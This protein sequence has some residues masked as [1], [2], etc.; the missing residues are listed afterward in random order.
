MKKYHVLWKNYFHKLITGEDISNLRQFVESVSEITVEDL[1]EASNIDLIKEKAPKILEKQM[2]AVQKIL[3][4]ESASEGWK[5]KK[6]NYADIQL[7]ST[8][9]PGTSLLLFKIIGDIK[10]SFDQV[11]YFCSDPT[12]W[13][14]INPS[15]KN[16]RTLER[17]TDNLAIEY[18]YTT[19]PFISDRD[20]VA[21]RY[22]E[23]LE[24]DGFAINCQISVEHDDCPPIKGCVRIDLFGGNIFRQIGKNH[25]KFT[26]ITYVDAKGML[27]HAPD[28]II[29][30]AVQQQADNLFKLKKF[31]ESNSV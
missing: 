12:N 29:K 9:M 17:F 1:I 18:T 10:C 13:N 24:E 14:K 4:I 19:A 31:M 3:S 23:I 30:A 22:H 26:Q 8:K 6:T 27:K 2:E 16:F 20:I 28:F 5:Q 7:F 15:I 11:Y 25:M 21:L